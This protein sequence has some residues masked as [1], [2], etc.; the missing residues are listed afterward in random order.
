MTTWRGELLRG[1]WCKNRPR[2]ER[3]HFFGLFRILPS[4]RTAASR[5]LPA[6]LTRLCDTA[7]SPSNSSSS[8][9][10]GPTCP[11]GSGS[12]SW[13]SAI[14]VD[15][16]IGV[17]ACE[18][19]HH[20]RGAPAIFHIFNYANVRMT[21]PPNAGFCRGFLGDKTR[22]SSNS[23]ISSSARRRAFSA[24]CTAST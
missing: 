20:Q 6:Q 13:L 3:P 10:P 21:T 18:F 4:E 8:V 11:K 1:D 2:V 22:S 12:L 15:S 23:S 7:H 14:K 17:G 5:Q 16:H 9:R 19:T 24:S